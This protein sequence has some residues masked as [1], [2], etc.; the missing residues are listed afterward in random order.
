MRAL[1]E[2]GGA[3]ARRRG[4][5]GCQRAAW[6]DVAGPSS[7]WG[8]GLRELRPPGASGAAGPRRAGGGGGGELSIAFFFFFDFWMQIF[9]TKL[10][11][12]LF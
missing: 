9:F 2:D 10:F 3:V 4:A 1:V 11:P 12:K 7:G 8:E 6:R 5:A